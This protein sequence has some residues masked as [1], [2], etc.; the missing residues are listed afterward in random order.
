ETLRL[1]LPQL[2]QDLRQQERLEAARELPPLPTRDLALRLQR[3]LGQLQQN[4]RQALLRQARHEAPP[5]ERTQ[6]PR[7]TPRPPRERVR[8]PAHRPQRPAP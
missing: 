4:V 7:R 6:D 5:P 3:R 1:H 8:A 2:H